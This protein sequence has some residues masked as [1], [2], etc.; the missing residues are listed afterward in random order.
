MRKSRRPALVAAL[1]AATFA[2]AV[3]A[4]ATAATNSDVSSNW[5]GY[6]AV[7]KSSRPSTRFKRVA[8]SWVVPAAACTG[9]ETY[10]SAWVGLGGYSDSSQALE[11]IGTDS[12]CSTAGR[13]SYS[14]WFE[15]VPADSVDIHI[16]LSPGDRMSASVEARGG[17][18][19]L[20]LRNRTRG[21]RFSTSKPMSRPDLTSAE[22]ILEAPDACDSQSCDALALAD[23]GSIAFT[24][25]ST[26]TTSGRSGPIASPRW[27]ATMLA[28]R[29]P[30]GGAADSSALSS[31]GRSFSVRYRAVTSSSKRAYRRL[32]PR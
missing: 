1:I 13:G 20:R 27:A 11:Q 14:A 10:S 16:K 5:A 15:L 3:P 9:R 31:A 29:D 7:P 23:F 32:G 28:L 18:V 8:A 30:A 24:G 25:A 12:D 4:A 17:R 6:V 21:T 2:V 22:W 19:L 26:K